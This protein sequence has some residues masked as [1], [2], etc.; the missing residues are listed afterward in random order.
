M[1]CFERPSAHIDC[2]DASRVVLNAA[3]DRPCGERSKSGLYVSR[4]LVTGETGRKPFHIEIFKTGRF[5]RCSRKIAVAEHRLQEGLNNLALRG[6]LSVVIPV[7]ILMRAKPVI[8]Q[9]IPRSRIET[10]G[11]NIGEAESRSQCRQ[12]LQ[13]R[14]AHGAR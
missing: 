11:F 9:R 8:K 12:C 14:V 4:R 10:A 3:K 1:R 6:P 7:P 2:L 5:W 13:L